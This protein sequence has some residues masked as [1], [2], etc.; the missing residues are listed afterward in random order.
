MFFR[1]IRQKIILRHSLSGLECVS[2]GLPRA[3]KISVR[4]IV[5][6]ELVRNGTWESDDC[7]FVQGFK[8]SV[9]QG[10]IVLHEY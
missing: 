1:R 4:F 7:E 8:D 5:W 2:G 9:M 10:L 6:T 3:S